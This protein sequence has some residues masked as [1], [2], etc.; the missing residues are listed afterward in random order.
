MSEK[1]VFEKIID[2]EI[3]SSIVYEDQDTI[4]FFDANPFEKG[5]ILVVPKKVYE[6][7]WQMPEDEYLMLQKS[8]LRVVKRVNEVFPDVGLNIVQN[9]RAIAHQDVFHVH[10][11]IIPRKIEKSLYMEYTDVRYLDRYE[12]EEEKHKFLELLKIG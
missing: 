12:S 1:T 4:A 11:H 3:P 5:H 7:V 8:L 6:Y 9:N 2:R 10:F